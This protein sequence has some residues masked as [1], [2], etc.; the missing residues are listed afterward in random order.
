MKKGILLL[1]ILSILAGSLMGCGVG[2]SQEMESLEGRREVKIL[3]EMTTVFRRERS[4]YVD[5]ETGEKTEAYMEHYRNEYGLRNKVKTF[6]ND[7]K[8]VDD[9]TDDIFIEEYDEQNR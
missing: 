5:S 4:Y 3:K 9:S 1:C 2:E 8:L 6:A 7:G